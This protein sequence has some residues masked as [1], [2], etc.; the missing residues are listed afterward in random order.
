M[1]DCKSGDIG[2]GQKVLNEFCDG[3]AKLPWNICLLALIGVVLLILTST[4]VGNV[5]TCAILGGDRC[6]PMVKIDIDTSSRIRNSNS[7]EFRALA[8]K[9]KEITKFHDTHPKM[10]YW[11]VSLTMENIGYH[12]PHTVKLTLDIR[13]NKGKNKGIISACE[14]DS[15]KYCGIFANSDG[16]FDNPLSATVLAYQMQKT[17][18]GSRGIYIDLVIAIPNNFNNTLRIFSTVDCD[19]CV[20]KSQLHE[21][22]LK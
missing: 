17:M 8:S 14:S 2:F 4:Y 18:T 21:N 11:K 13:D 22:V 5:T 6:S 15:S 12:D 7:N 9:F 10:T 19:L 16:T 3:V 20:I 1:V